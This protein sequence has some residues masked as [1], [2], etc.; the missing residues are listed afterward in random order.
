MYPLSVFRAPQSMIYF[1]GLTHLGFHGHFRIISGLHKA[2]WEFG[3]SLPFIWDALVSHSVLQPMTLIHPSWVF[4]HLSHLLGLLL[5]SLLPASPSGSLDICLCCGTLQVY[6]QH[7][8]FEGGICAP[9][10]VRRE[11]VGLSQLG[12]VPGDLTH[13]LCSLLRTSSW[14]PF[15][16]M[17]RMDTRVTAPSAARG[18]PC[19]SV[20]VQTVLGEA[21]LPIAPPKGAMHNV[22]SGC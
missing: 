4:L 15:S 1:S 22:G 6:K 18:V 20:R 3:D 2:I 8:L 19:S 14:K 12:T 17:M 9:C 7:P 16:F 13:S 21:Q 11:T 10:K 5:L